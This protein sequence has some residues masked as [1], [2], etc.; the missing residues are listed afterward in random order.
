MRGITPSWLIVAIVAQLATYVCVAGIY[1]S[2]FKLLKTG[3][4][5]SFQ[6]FY[7]F[8]ILIVFVNQALPSGGL[9]GSAFL[10]R[11][12]TKKGTTAARAFLIFILYSMYYWVDTPVVMSGTR[13]LNIST[14]V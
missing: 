9:S 4:T 2:L 3:I 13:Q 14:L 7:T 10:F 11:Q 5:Y 6:E 12:S 1:K 8:A